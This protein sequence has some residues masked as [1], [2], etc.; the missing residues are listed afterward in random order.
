MT[1]WNKCGGVK[2][3]VEICAYPWRVVESQSIL[4]SRNLVD[5]AKEYDI[6]EGL[7]ESSKPIVNA[8]NKGTHYLIFTPFRYPPLKYGSRFGSRLEPSLWYG[9]LEVET[10]LSEVAFYRM[11]FLHHTDADL[12]YV[13]TSLTAYQSLIKTKK[14]INLTAEPFNHYEQQLSSK[15]DYSYS[16]AMGMAMREAGV[17]TFSYYSAR[18]IKKGENIAA[19]TPEV[20]HKKNNDYVFN[21]Q[22][23]QCSANK[24]SVDF[25]DQGHNKVRFIF[26]DF[27]N[28]GE[29]DINP[30]WVSFNPTMS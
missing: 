20:F 22:T 7:L 24:E 10:A 8:A 13:N 2:N 12:G 18:S 30:E 9:S 1:I 29:L 6:L 23:W 3:F 4:T 25:A 5:T 26:S 21:Y 14:G 11:L 19:F 28:K 17:E 27:S 16:Q 15:N